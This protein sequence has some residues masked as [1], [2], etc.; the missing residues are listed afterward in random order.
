M[1]ITCVHQ[2]YELYGSDRSFVESVRIFRAAYP[3][4]V[5]DV[6]L[7]RTGPIVA[8]LEGVASRIVFEPLWILRRRDLPRLA[9]LGLLTLP[10][11]MLRAW[12][13]LRA[14]DLVYI[15]TS[16]VADYLLAARLCPGRAIVHVHEIPQGATLKLLRGLIRWSGA[17][18]VFN[19]RATAKA[20]SLTSKVAMR[21]VYNGIAGPETPPASTYDGSRPL[22]LLMLGRISRIKGQEILV[23]AIRS[24]PPEVRARIEVRIVGSAFED[25][26]REEALGRQIA[27][28]GL[29]SIIRLSPFVDDPS[30]LYRW[31]DVVTVPS[32]LPESLGRV[33]IEAM[34]YG[35]PPVVSRIGGLTEVVEEGS[36]GWVVTP[37]DAPSL[38]SALERIVT[39]P[40]SWQ[41]F[42]AAA[43]ARYAALFGEAAAAEGLVAMIRARIG[44]RAGVDAS[45]VAAS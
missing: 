35:R 3:A 42:P 10:V 23:E 29:G 40:V 5:I 24:L 43:R 33:A 26:A 4:A 15:N 11:A 19:S 34:A 22:R 12:R 21:V 31:A 30:D 28:A 44:G 6:V 7:P 18:I 13:R 1:R 41:D 20:F 16:V 38:A 32:R 45:A 17:D 39:D 27:D 2:G 36:S 14:S 9:T 37:D 8:A 25:T